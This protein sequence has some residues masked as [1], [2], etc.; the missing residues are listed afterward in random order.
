MQNWFLIN[1]GDA[2]LADPEQ[3]RIKE[4]LESEYGNIGNPE[5]MAAFIRH[6]SE[7]RLHCD[8]KIYLSPMSAAIAKELGARPCAKP[9]PEGLGLLAGPQA[10]WA[11][12]FPAN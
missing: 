11:T 7:G 6:E 4:R 3:E 8:A 1:L 10:A 2:M 9:G 5:E 12:L